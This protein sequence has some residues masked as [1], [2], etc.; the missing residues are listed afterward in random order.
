VIV[1]LHGACGDEN[2]EKL[3]HF[4]PIKYGLDHD[5]FGFIAVAPASARGWSINGLNTFL[6][7]LTRQMPAIDSNRVYLTGYSMGAQ[8]TW[9][10]AAAFPHRF[11]AIA[12]VAGSANPNYVVPRMRQVP[13]WVFHGARDT[14]IP[15]AYGRIMIQALE[16]AGAE[17]KS[18]I[19][20]NCGHEVWEVAYREDAL[21]QWFLDHP[22]NHS[23]SAF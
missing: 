19:Y 6:N 16:K 23:P 7:Q 3:K 9:A 2:R 10:M 4:G 5:E 8:A 1:F 11:A 20:P 12:P 15:A 17:V 22:K 13:V 18:T 21:Y 14:V